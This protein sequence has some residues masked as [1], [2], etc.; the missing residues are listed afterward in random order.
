L[1]FG[2]RGPA[3]KV[4]GTDASDCTELMIS[5]YLISADFQL[6]VFAD[7]CPQWASSAPKALNGCDS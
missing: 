2:A 1:H 3:T 7:L 6:T 4:A 5:C